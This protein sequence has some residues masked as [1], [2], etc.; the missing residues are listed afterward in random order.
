MCWPETAIVYG[1]GNEEVSGSLE[2]SALL[3]APERDERAR[4]DFRIRIAYLQLRN[5]SLKVIVIEKRRRKKEKIA[6]KQLTKQGCREGE[7]PTPGQ[8]RT[9]WPRE[10]LIE[11]QRSIFF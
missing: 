11:G 8:P 10:T 4:T 1:E 7:A 9:T 2:C 6:T 5:F 3:L